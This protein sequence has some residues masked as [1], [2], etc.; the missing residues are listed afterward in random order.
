MSILGLLNA[1]IS[2]LFVFL[3]LSAIASTLLE[4]VFVGLF[5]TRARQL[6]QTVEQLCK[7]NLTPNT[8][9]DALFLKIWNDPL[10]LGSGPKGKD[11]SYIDPA[12]FVSAVIS[13]LTAGSQAPTSTALQ[14]GVAAMPAGMAL[15]SVLTSLL[16][17][18]SGDIDALRSS[19][20]AW[21]DKGMDRLSGSYKRWSQFW[22]FLM[23]VVLAVGM[24]VDCFKLV[25]SVGKA[26]VSA[27]AS[28]AAAKIIADQKSD[29]GAA[30]NLEDMLKTLDSLSLPIGWKNCGDETKQERPAP[31]ANA[32]ATGDTKPASD[33]GSNAKDTATCVSS[34]AG[35][36]SDSTEHP[37]NCVAQILGWL[38]TGFLISFGA[39]FW[40]DL[41]S[42]FINIRSGGI[43][44]TTA[45]QTPAK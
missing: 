30:L 24:N 16:R 18:G 34:L 35:F 13:E 25:Q 44:I 19:L 7:G 4:Q 6:R 20:S 2:F 42:K 39:P 10:I 11:P 38:L 8:P 5:G 21:F 9:E 12:S 26:E 43:Q 14:T 31:D 22:L 36:L 40:F 41:V 33:A 15:K 29:P 17:E 23:G 3:L 27:I 1:I 32:G 28:E 45:P 37:G